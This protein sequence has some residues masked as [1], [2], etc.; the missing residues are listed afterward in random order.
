[1]GAILRTG[2][3][4]CAPRKSPARA[5]ALDSYKGVRS[6]GVRLRP[7]KLAD[8]GHRRLD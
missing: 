5:E 7:L 3:N 1:M 6:I 2:C 4:L 8:L